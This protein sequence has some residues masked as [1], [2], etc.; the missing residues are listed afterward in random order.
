MRKKVLIILMAMIICLLNSFLTAA[1]VNTQV[2][3]KNNPFYILVN[4]QNGVGKAYKPSDLVIPNVKFMEVGLLEKKHMQSTAAYYLKIMFNQASKQNIHLIAISGYRSYS[5]QNTIYNNYI[6]KYGEAYTEKV[7]AKSGH[8]EHQTGLA[9]DI[10]AKS[11]RYHLTQDFANTKEGKWLA[12]NAHH[13]GFIIRYPKG[14]EHITGYM[15]EPWHV[16]YIGKELAAYLYINGLVLEEMDSFFEKQDDT[17]LLADEGTS[18]SNEVIP[19]KS[20]KMDKQIGVPEILQ[21]EVF[22]NIQP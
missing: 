11:V 16:R 18:V 1:Q 13:Y 5:R 6:S 12:E 22:I 4:K 19:S 15:Y 14:K 7:S 8:S 21:E 20:E 17:K 9:M 10:S 2:Y 3:S